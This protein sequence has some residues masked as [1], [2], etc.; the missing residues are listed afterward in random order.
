MRPKNKI[1]YMNGFV[2]TDP[3]LKSNLLL[4]IIHKLLQYPE[5]PNALSYRWPSLLS[6]TAFYHSCKTTK[7]HYRVC[8]ASEWH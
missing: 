5:T 6:Q 3:K 7:V 2:K 8:G 4:N 1:I